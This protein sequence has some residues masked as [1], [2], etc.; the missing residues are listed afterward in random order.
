MQVNKIRSNNYFSSL[1][2]GQ[3]LANKVLYSTTSEKFLNDFVTIK[4]SII[5]NKLDRK[6]FVDILLQE[7]DN[8]FFAIIASK[9]QGVPISPASKIDFDASN[10]GLSKLKKW[11]NSWNQAYNPKALEQSKKLDELI[12]SIY[13]QQQI[14]V[15]CCDVFLVFFPCSHYKRLSTP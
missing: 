11:V 4:N 6:K 13:N 15:Q 14:L 10:K 2:V 7:N 9:E 1:F 3:S 5:V 12:N 8:K